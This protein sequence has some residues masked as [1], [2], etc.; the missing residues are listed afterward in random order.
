MAR[1]LHLNGPSGIGKSTLARRWAD[2]RPGTLDLD[3]DQVVP[4]LG[5]WR[6]D[7]GAAL[8]PARRLALAMAAAHLASGKDVVLPQLVTSEAEA[9][10]F[11]A[12]AT[13]AG[14]TYVEV[15]LLVSTAEQTERFTAKRRV[16]A[17]ER[18]VGN[19]L[20]ERGGETVLA[21]IHAHHRDYLAHRPRAL[22]LSTDGHSPDETYDALVTLLAD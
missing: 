22:R 1:L 13:D 7:F 5:G 9:C 14:A 8:A 11:E 3:V 21:R 2:E 17:V 18:H 15:A 12:A 19:Y 6:D 16:T 20:K 4:L 10:R